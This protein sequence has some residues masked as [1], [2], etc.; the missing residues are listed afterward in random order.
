MAAGIIRFHIDAVCAVGTAGPRNQDILQAR[1][2]CGSRQC[3]HSH[4]PSRNGG[5]TGNSSPPGGQT[6]GRPEAAW[7]S[8]G[9]GRATTGHLRP[10]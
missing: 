9:S 3:R 6:K 4:R 10:A 5:W 2:S 8:L 7:L 1:R